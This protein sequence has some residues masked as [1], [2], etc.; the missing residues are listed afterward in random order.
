LFSV[1]FKYDEFGQFSGFD[2]PEA[3]AVREFYV[4]CHVVIDAFNAVD[5]FVFVHK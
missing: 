3:A 4:P 5:G 2:V 1:R